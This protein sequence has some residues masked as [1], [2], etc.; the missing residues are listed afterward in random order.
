MD[1]EIGKWILHFA[2]FIIVNCD[3]VALARLLCVGRQRAQ[4]DARRN[5]G[6]VRV[7]ALVSG[8]AHPPWCH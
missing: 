5:R 7:L 4:S 3:V 2:A 6:A 1:F 8:R